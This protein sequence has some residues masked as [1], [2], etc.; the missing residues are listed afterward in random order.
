[1]MHGTYIVKLTIVICR[2]IIK[3]KRITFDS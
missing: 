3:I 1:M 2:T